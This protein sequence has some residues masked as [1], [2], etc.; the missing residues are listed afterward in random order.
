MV[1]IALAE[2]SGAVSILILFNDVMFSTVELT[3]TLPR[4]RM[5]GTCDRG[6]QRFTSENICSEGLKSPGIFGFLFKK[7]Q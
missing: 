5:C 7:L 1:I 6:T 4:A 3:Q 2:V